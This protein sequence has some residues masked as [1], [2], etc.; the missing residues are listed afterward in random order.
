MTI[1]TNNTIEEEYSF[2]LN[3][4]AFLCVH[5]NTGNRWF[6]MWHICGELTD[7]FNLVSWDKFV[8]TYSNNASELQMYLN[9]HPNIPNVDF[10]KIPSY[11]FGF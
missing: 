4:M 9:I 1:I 7:I 2:A 8:I 5:F 11:L 6:F 3:Q 10:F